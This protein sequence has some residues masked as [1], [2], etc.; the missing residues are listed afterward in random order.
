MA[1]VGSWSKVRSL[2][3]PIQGNVPSIPIKDEC[4]FL[5]AKNLFVGFRSPQ[6]K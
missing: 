6:M 4:Q 2:D 5:G 3:S 1:L